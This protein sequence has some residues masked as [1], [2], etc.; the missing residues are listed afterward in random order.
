MAAQFMPMAG[1][2]VPPQAMYGPGA[3]VAQQTWM[4]GDEMQQK[5]AKAGGRG[6]M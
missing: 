5:A 3:G 4:R 6:R 1:M 2:A